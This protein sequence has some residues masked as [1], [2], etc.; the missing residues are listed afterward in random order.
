MKNDY[1]MQEE[2]QRLPFCHELYS[3]TSFRMKKRG[4]IL[5]KVEYLKNER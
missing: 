4:A 1:K 2:I 3:I 5:L